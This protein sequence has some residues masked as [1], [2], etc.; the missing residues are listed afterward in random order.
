MYSS[1]A[2]GFLSEFVE[3]SRYAKGDGRLVINLNRP[4]LAVLH[5]DGLAPADYW[6]S[7]TVDGRGRQTGRG[8]RNSR[9]KSDKGRLRD[10]ASQ[11]T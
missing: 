9:G 1:G 3:Q 4:L 11:S 7:C 5:A 8:R 10:S 6:D 2:I